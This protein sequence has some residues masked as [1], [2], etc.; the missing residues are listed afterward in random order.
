[1]CRARSEV[2]DFEPAQHR[3]RLVVVLDH[4]L[5]RARLEDGN[6]LLQLRQCAAVGIELLQSLS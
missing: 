4:A 6:L 2:A 5:R 3:E 1:L